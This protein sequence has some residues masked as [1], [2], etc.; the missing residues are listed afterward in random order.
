MQ[1][2]LRF[3]FYFLVPFILV[4]HLRPNEG[5]IISLDF[6][7]FGRGAKD[8]ISSGSINRPT[9]SSETLSRKKPKKDDGKNR[10]LLSILHPQTT[11]N[12]VDTD[13]IDR[14]EFAQSRGQIL[15]FRLEL[16]SEESVCAN[17]L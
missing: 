16:Q 10:I 5:N 4:H 17:Q 15:V 7:F 9:S 3:I 1:I 6:V 13:Q 8:S 2:I 12:Y 11:M 14:A